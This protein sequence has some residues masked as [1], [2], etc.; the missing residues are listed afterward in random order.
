MSMPDLRQ[1]GKKQ[2]MSSDN[3]SSWKHCTTSLGAGGNRVLG[4]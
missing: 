4:K 3:R 2:V 1:P